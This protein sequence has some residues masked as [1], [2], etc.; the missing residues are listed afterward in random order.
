MKTLSA[1]SVTAMVLISLGAAP[2]LAQSNGSS[3][4]TT[5][6]RSTGPNTGQNNNA[7]NTDNTTGDA[8][9][10]KAPSVAKG[11][12]SYTE[13]QARDRIAQAGYTDVQSLKLSNDGIWSA[14]AMKGGS[15]V[16]V[17]LDYKGNVAQ[18]R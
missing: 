10:T 7:V 11:A 4:G 13:S 3:T 14:T 8:A 12:N 6:T 17:M 9:N 15:H 2:C 18:Q 16:S 5:Q 1:A